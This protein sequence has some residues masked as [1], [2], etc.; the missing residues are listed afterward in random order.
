[1]AGS[2]M[3]WLFSL[4]GLCCIALGLQDTA[5]PDHAPAEA[6]QQVTSAQATPDRSAWVGDAA[7]ASCHK[8]E[9]ETY[10]HTSHH[11][12]SLLADAR[13]IL[14]SFT[15]PSSTLVISN[16]DEAAG[17]PHLFFQM[18]AR[19]DGFYQTAVAELGDRKL[20][21]SER[22]DIVI[23]S[24]T[25]GQTYL[26]WKDTQLFELPVSFWSDGHQWINSPG[27]RDGTAN[28]SRHVDPRCMEC[29]STYLQALSNDPQT[30]L[31]NSAS[32]MTGITCESCHGPGLAHVNKEKLSA[33][34][35]KPALDSNILNPAKFNRDR[36]VDQ[37]ALCHNGTE[38]EE[39][40]PAFSYVPGQD[41]NRFLAPGA[42]DA[43]D[44]PDVHGNQVGLLK[45]SPCYLGSPAMTCST[46]HN[47]HAPER[48]AAEYSSRC[49]QCHR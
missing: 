47:E 37:C 19:P 41:L 24:G 7:C 49:L 5:G 4:V 29:H 48:A 42:V 28:F 13:S 25:R 12:T 44:H 20:T 15:G 45:K 3:V 18:D 33:K 43:T 39:L 35:R 23:G 30:N 9:A 21:H 8:A 22:F 46:C 36:Q 17:T 16:A 38:R 11:L 6:A 32:L 10:S 40:A 2:V 31:Y 27:Y 1:M 14:G 34:Q 26:Y